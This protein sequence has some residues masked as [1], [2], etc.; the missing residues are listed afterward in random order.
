MEGFQGGLSDQPVPVGGI[1][2][3]LGPADE[4]LMAGGQ[5]HLDDSSLAMGTLVNR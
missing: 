4:M 1:S 2:V 5:C 3:T